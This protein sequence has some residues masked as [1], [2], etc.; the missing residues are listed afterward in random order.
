MQNIST[1]IQI[2]LSKLGIETLTP[3]QN[4]AIKACSG[5]QDVILLSPTGSGK[6][7]GFLI[8]L[9]E[10]F[11]AN[12]EGIQAL[13]LTPSRELAI[14]IEQVFKKLTTDF[15]VNCCYGGHSTKIERN[16]LSHPP[17]LLVGTPGR[18]ADH[19]RRG[20]IDTRGIKTLVLD[21]FDKAL[22]FGFQ[23]E[24]VYIIDNL[25]LKKRILTSATKSESIPLFTG[26]T[27]P[28]ELNYLSTEQPQRLVVKK[29]IANGKDKLD[30]LYRLICTLG[31]ATTL[32]FCNH[33][34]AVGRISDLLYQ[35]GLEH[36]IFHG[37]LEQDDRERALIKFRNGSHHLLI[38]T[39]LASRGLDIPEIK[40]II[41]YQLPQTEDVFIHRNGRTARMTANGSAYLIL[42]EEDYLPNFI[43]GDVEEQDISAILPPPAQPEWVTL[44]ISAGKKDKINKVDIVGLLLQKGGLAKNELGLI[45]VLD[46]TSYVAI[47]R[48]KA[49]ETVRLLR[50]ETLKRKRIKMEISE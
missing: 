17:T 44:Y 28:I 34:E 43:E 23:N 40:H 4:E 42:G 47:N 49:G 2:A 32:I 36:D 22:E 27:N 35:K 24:M 45:E 12:E 1:P 33:R 48:K 29:V 50:D 30:A 15:K 46:K 25:T 7:L 8:P 11:T 3:M 14:Q 9:V 39:D 16:N 10:S 41:H 18:I 21:E 19:I 37:G 38:T 31:N 6:T 13:I 26:I 5:Q 20:I